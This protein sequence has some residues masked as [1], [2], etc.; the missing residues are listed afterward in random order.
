M[1]ELGGLVNVGMSDQEKADA[2]RAIEADLAPLPVEEL[3]PAEVVQIARAARERIYEGAR[4]K[5]RE[6]E[7]RSARRAAL[8]QVGL[9]SARE[10]LAE[11][12]DDWIERWQSENEIKSL[13]EKKLTGDETEFEV[14][15]IVERAIPETGPEDLD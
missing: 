11:E 3:P 15:A 1:H 10:I 14:L 8:I 12:L 9:R 2:L 5:A 6:R 13:L 7:Q 4:R